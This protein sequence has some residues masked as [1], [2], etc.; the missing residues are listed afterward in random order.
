MKENGRWDEILFKEER[1][2]SNLGF[3]RLK[4]TDSRVIEVE[5]TDLLESS[6]AE[7]WLR[8]EFI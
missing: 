6:E 5:S 4:G 8:V 3:F 2:F 7:S 1:I